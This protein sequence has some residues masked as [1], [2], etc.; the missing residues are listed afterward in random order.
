MWAAAR[1][2]EQAVVLLLGAGADPNALDIVCY[3]T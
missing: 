3:G 2:N 1:G